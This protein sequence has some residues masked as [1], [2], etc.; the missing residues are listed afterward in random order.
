MSKTKIH[1]QM[2]MTKRTDI[3]EKM[4]KILAPIFH[5]RLLFFFSLLFHNFFLYK[6]GQEKST[7]FI[8]MCYENSLN[9]INKTHI[10]LHNKSK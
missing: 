2:M 6:N 3:V 9:E 4:W 1:T 10:L 7:M 8:S 5:K